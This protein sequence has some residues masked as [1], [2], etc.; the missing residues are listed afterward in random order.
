M[1]FYN[2]DDVF[3][4][5]I[6]DFDPTYREIFN[7]V[8]LELKTNYYDADMKIFLQIPT[9]ELFQEQTINTLWTVK[10]I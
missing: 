6:Y 9:L 7:I 2:L 8:L 1:N 10:E 5:I 4:R 3:K